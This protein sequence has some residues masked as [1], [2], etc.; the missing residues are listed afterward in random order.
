MYELIPLNRVDD[1]R[2]YLGKTVLIVVSG[3][4][5]TSADAQPRRI[6]SQSKLLEY[7]A[8]EIEDGLPVAYRGTLPELRGQQLT[9][10]TQ[11]PFGQSEYATLFY[12]DNH[13]IPAPSGWFWGESETRMFIVKKQ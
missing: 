2:P 5:F 7:L 1:I 10:Q 9:K 4:A 3:P 11:I 13:Y 12:N 6:I 8:N